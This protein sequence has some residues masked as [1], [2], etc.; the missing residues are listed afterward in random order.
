MELSRFDLA[1]IKQALKLLIQVD[2][3]VFGKRILQRTEQNVADILT[4]YSD[5]TGFS[6]QPNKPEE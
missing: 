5:A 3:G 6:V 1:I 4:E 2:N